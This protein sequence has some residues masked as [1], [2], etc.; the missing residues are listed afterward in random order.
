[1]V[2]FKYMYA[3]MFPYNFLMDVTVSI[4]LNV[5]LRSRVLV[6]ILLVY[7]NVMSI[8]ILTKENKLLLN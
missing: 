7:Y 1:M 4:Y 5:M 6:F 8:A 2:W 3:F